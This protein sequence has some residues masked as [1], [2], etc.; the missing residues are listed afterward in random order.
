MNDNYALI[1]QLKKTADRCTRGKGRER[2]VLN[3][4]SKKTSVDEFH[5]INMPVL[6]LPK[7]TEPKP[8]KCAENPDSTDEEPKPHEVK[9]VKVDKWSEGK[10][11]FTFNEICYAEGTLEFFRKTI[12]KRVLADTFVETEDGFSEDIGSIA[13]AFANDEGTFSLKVI[14]YYGKHYYELLT[15]NPKAKC[16]YI[17]KNIRHSRGA[18]TIESIKLEMPVNNMDLDIQFSL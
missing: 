11:G 15:D 18:N 9:L 7:K 14:L 17:L 8:V 3:S 10:N 5:D 13:E 6:N 4:N 12:R 1:N 2:L 16:W